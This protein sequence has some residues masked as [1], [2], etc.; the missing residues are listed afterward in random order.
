MVLISDWDHSEEERRLFH[1][2]IFPACSGPIDP[3]FALFKQMYRYS[4][5]GL[6]VSSRQTA[7]QW[8]YLRLD[9]LWKERFNELYWS[10]YPFCDSACLLF[11]INSLGTH[12]IHTWRGQVSISVAH[13][14]VMVQWWGA[15]HWS[16]TNRVVAV[17][18]TCHWHD[19]I[20]KLCK[21]YHRVYPNAST[22]CQQCEV[23]SGIHHQY[24]I[25]PPNPAHSLSCWQTTHG[26]YGSQRRLGCDQTAAEVV[27]LSWSKMAD[28]HTYGGKAMKISV[29]TKTRELL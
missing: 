25:I 23:I 15:K 2:S 9:K 16:Y 17:S 3:L 27:V 20:I 19:T 6:F 26:I 14:G 11:K 10:A 24:D 5:C 22:S 29:C 7:A 18:V 28:G 13:Q 4:I 1:H 21:F 12:R 8:G